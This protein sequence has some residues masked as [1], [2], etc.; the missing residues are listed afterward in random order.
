MDGSEPVRVK[1]LRETPLVG[2]RGFVYVSEV[3]DTRPSWH[4]SPRLIA[5]HPEISVPLEMPMITWAR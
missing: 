4:F 3:P 5:F 2:A 1:M